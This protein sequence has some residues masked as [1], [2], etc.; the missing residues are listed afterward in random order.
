MYAIIGVTSFGIQ[1]GDR[2]VPAVYTRV[3]NYTDW[4]EEHVWKSEHTD[5]TF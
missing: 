5:I 4:I 1:C 2:A 3:F